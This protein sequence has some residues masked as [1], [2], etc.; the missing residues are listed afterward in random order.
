[1]KLAVISLT[2][3]TYRI[4][5][6]LIE[7]YEIQYILEKDYKLR[8]KNGCFQVV[9]MW[10]GMDLYRLGEIDQFLLLCI[11]QGIVLTSMYFPLKNGGIPDKDI[12]Y[13]PYHVVYAERKSET[14]LNDIVEFIKRK[15][16]DRL[17][18]LINDNSN[19]KCANCS[20]F[21]GLVDEKKCTDFEMN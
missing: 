1:M 15:E 10:R 21:A 6:L 18:L 20:M 9:S 3:E 7:K 16:L 8:G 4:L 11:R 19:L 12:L 14:L 17:E 5:P 2:E 13:A